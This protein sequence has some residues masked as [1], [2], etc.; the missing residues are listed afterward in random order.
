MNNG[1]KNN[2][3][4]PKSSVPKIFLIIN[5]RQKEDFSKID[6]SDECQISSSK[7]F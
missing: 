2:E 3:Q 7:G 6:L 4:Q 5:V 1:S